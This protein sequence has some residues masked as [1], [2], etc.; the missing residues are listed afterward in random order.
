MSH[1]TGPIPARMTRKGPFTV[2]VAGSVSVEGETIPRRN[3]RYPDK[4]LERPEEG[5]NTMVDFI[6]TSAIKFGDAPA[7]GTRKL[8]KKHVETKKIKKFVNGVEEEVHKQW[9]YFEMSGYNYIS[10]KE[11]ELLTHQLGWGLRK[12]GMEAPD[13]LHMFASTW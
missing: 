1:P 12:L 2:E 5:I 11:L 6:K 4:L 7:L 9:T 13:R 10:F 8:I 3:A